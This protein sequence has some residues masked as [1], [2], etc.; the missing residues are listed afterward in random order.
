MI[1]GMTMYWVTRI[2]ALNDTLGI[3]YITGIIILIAAGIGMLVAAAND[4]FDTPKDAADFA[5]KWIA[6][7]AVVT[8][9][10]LFIGIFTPNKDDMVLIAGAELTKDAATTPEAAMLRQWVDKELSTQID[11]LSDK[12]TVVVE[13]AKAINGDKQ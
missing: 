11:K 2:I 5:K 1:S 3:I 6:P 4:A 12:A 9:L 10:A 7:I 8:A 13:K